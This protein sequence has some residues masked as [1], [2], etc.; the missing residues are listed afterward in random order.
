MV[1]AFKAVYRLV[2]AIALIVLVLLAL[3]ASLGR[4]YIGLLAD[5]RQQILAEIETRAGVK[6][7]LSSLSAEWSGLA[8]VIQVQN[9]QIGDQQAIKIGSASIEVNVLS[10]MLL[11]RP[12]FNQIRVSALR[13]DLYQREADGKWYV[14]GLESDEST[15]SPDWLLDTVLGIRNARLDTLTLALHYHSGI[16]KKLVLEGFSLEGDDGFRRIFARLNTE[17]QGTISLQSETYGDPRDKQGFH[18]AAYLQIDKSR[19]SA[20]APLFQEEAS[21][22]DS[23]VSG[24][25]WLNW[26]RDQR[27]NLVAE[28]R[29]PELAVGALWNAP[30][31]RLQ[32]VNMRF[33]GNHADDS[34]HLS[35]ADFDA[36]W[37][38]QQLNLDGI[39]LHQSASDQWRLS[40]PSLA[41]DAWVSLLSETKAFPGQSVLT[42]LSP[43]GALRH[44]RVT[45]QRPQSAEQQ[46]AFKLR[47]ELD[48][49]AVS[50]WRGAP[51]AEGVSGYIEVT[52]NE[53]RVVLKSAQARLSFPKLY[54]NVFA[55]QDVQG[56]LS[57]I[58][59]E[60]RLYLRSGLIQAENEGQP[61]K[62]SL[63]LDLPLTKE[64]DEE[65]SPA[66][67]LAIAAKEADVLRHARYTPSVLNA[68]LL[69]WLDASLLG[70]RVSEAAFLYHGSL[71]KEE[72]DKR[73]IQL[74][75]ALSEG[76]LKFL[77]DWPSVT[78][79]DAVLIL[80]NHHF[81]ATAAHAQML[82]VDIPDVAVEIVEN[83]LSKP[84]LHIAAKTEVAFAE[85]KRVL[86]K[87]PIQQ[88]IGHFMDDWHGEGKADVDFTLR[89]QLSD[90]QQPEIDVR[91][92][93]GLEHLALREQNL[94]LGDV[95]GELSF[96]TRRGLFSDNLQANLFGKAFTVGV[97]QQGTTVQVD[98]HG[99]VA[100][101]DL[102]RWLN[103]SVL[104]VL[105]GEA[106]VDMRI[107]AGGDTAAD[108][109]GG[110]ASSIVFHSNMKG[111]SLLLPQPLFKPEE[112]LRELSVAMPLQANAAENN[113]TITLQNSAQLALTR[114]DGKLLG[115]HVELGSNALAEAQRGRFLV[116]G[117]LDF[118]A[119]S[120]WQMAMERYLPNDG[121]ALNNNA[122]AS[123]FDLPVRLE[124][125]QLQELEA[126]GRVFHDVSVSA[127]IVNKRSDIEIVSDELAGNITI[128]ADTARAPMVLALDKLVLPSLT[129]SGGGSGGGLAEQDPRTFPSISLDV[130]EL[131][132][133]GEHWGSLGFD[134]H[135]DSRGAHFQNL[136][137][138]LR[139][140][141]LGGDDDAAN[142]FDWLRSA[143][144][145]SSQLQG[146]F[147]IRD[148]ASVLSQWGFPKIMEAERARVDIGLAWPGAP[149]TWQLASSEGDVAFDFDD[150]RF[151]RASDTASGALRILSIFNMANIVRRLKFD[152]RD[153]FSSGIAFD[154]MRGQLLI[155]DQH[156]NLQTPL[157]IKGPS[158]AFQMT[159]SVDMEN[160]VPDLRLVATLPIGS[161]LPWLAALVG[162]LPAA[163]GV[164]VVSKV[165]EEEVDS[166]S[167]AVYDISGTLQKP[168]LTFKQIFDVEDVVRDE[169]LR[170]K[171]EVTR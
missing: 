123:G 90:G 6:L 50:S 54:E 162:G 42:D 134:L 15:N 153:V 32:N 159:G 105:Q 26:R 8:P 106:A 12:Q 85:G 102:R 45:W 170:H 19:L 64:A 133:A 149:D 147:S 150:G 27:V 80:D 112:Q 91:V 135:S 107:V 28:L 148:F 146:V 24:N 137:G 53:G 121:E 76:E 11:Q 132:V 95:R 138:R 140:V 10:S 25:L 122:K 39:S 89:Q 98:G 77:S 66:M 144:G 120:Q 4:Q 38:D 20:L 43:Q 151:L 63:A 84:V 93:I 100:A 168:E 160:E 97:S 62:A 104:D 30:D 82:D 131:V 161:N 111:L 49:V 1:Q 96:D 69:Q 73:S 152:F 99:R 171:R 33:T 17:Q 3:Y 143:G 23:E 109:T 67:T 21:L 141:G 41:M 128:P 154:S 16:E 117:Q 70:G 103:L 165:F 5:Y 55:L 60:H 110:E 145:D 158:S 36:L 58:L 81:K 156:L 2:W 13:L 68:N 116:A 113:I 119:L 114:R 74:A 44:L 78:V 34:W 75:L 71:K 130:A 164:Y 157:V 56:E 167:S 87:T 18:G 40:L 46:V 92:D 108:N 57:W 166:F 35:F 65:K 7:Q 101:V 88:R 129:G 9:L 47:A 48:K 29:S 124:R 22:I 126:F 52:P 155:A 31:Y 59:D 139:G 79:K 169:T 136:R 125:L 83:S 163:A 115:G 142:R 127:D 37:Q 86:L 72:D 118:A 94:R 51:G 61:L 14:P